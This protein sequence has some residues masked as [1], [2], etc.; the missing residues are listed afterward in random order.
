[1]EDIDFF[2]PNHSS[3]GNS[4]HKRPRIEET[5][6][7]G[8][9]LYPPT[10]TSVTLEG[11]HELEKLDSNAGSNMDIIEQCSFLL[12]IRKK[13]AQ[14]LQESIRIEASASQS[15]RRLAQSLFAVHFLAAQEADIAS[16]CSRTIASM[17]TKRATA[18]IKRSSRVIVPLPKPKSPPREIVKLEPSLLPTGHPVAALTDQ[19]SDPPFWIRA[20]IV[21]FNSS[22]NRY[23]VQDDEPEESG[24][25][26]KFARGIYLTYRLYQLAPSK[27]IPIYSL[28][29]IPLDK[30][31]QFQPGDTVLALYPET[32]TFYSAKVV[33]TPKQVRMH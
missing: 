10:S 18:S 4:G 5:L 17:L 15:S 27:V 7:D 28:T 19:H 22:R 16:E 11:L 12:K 24:G 29:D 25:T 1:M 32:T 9:F 2:S 8:P 13:L 23:K 20:S 30:R 21:A 26:R 3:E 31:K 33:Q 14:V 6:S